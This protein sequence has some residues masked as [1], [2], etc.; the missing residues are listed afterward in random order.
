MKALRKLY[1]SLIPLA[2]QGLCGAVYTQLSDVEDE[3]NGLYTFDRAVLKLEPNQL[4][5]I[6][7]Q[8]KDA[9]K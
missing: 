4:S 3:T 2:K 5:D 8:L 9:V 6:V 1:L 7:V